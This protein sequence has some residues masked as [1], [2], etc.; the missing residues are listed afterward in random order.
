MESLLIH[1]HLFLAFFKTGLFSW[2]GGTAMIALMETECVGRY[3]WLTNEQFSEVI[4]GNAVVPGVFAVKFA[5][6]VGYQQA[7]L[8]GALTSCASIC[9]PGILLFV[10]FFLYIQKLKSYVTFDKFMDGIQFGAAGMILYSVLKVIPKMEGRHTQFAMGLV[11]MALVTIALKLKVDP[12]IAIIA[13]GMIGI[14][15]F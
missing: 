1:W 2:G 15:I 3:K 4:A 11:L 14:I 9:A 8:L 7:G 6:Y 10:P 12:V 13:A 5:A